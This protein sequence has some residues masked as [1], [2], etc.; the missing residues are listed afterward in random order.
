MIENTDPLV[1]GEGTAPE[2]A[3][4]REQLAV[5][6]RANRR[7]FPWRENITPYRIVV[8]VSISPATASNPACHTRCWSDS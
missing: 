5:F 2:I 7:D 4:F 8:S 1:S 3:R 6:Y